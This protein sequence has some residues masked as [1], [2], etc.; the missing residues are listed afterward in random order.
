MSFYFRPFHENSS[1]WYL[2]FPL[3]RFRK[4]AR[5]EQVEIRFNFCSSSYV[6]L[7]KMFQIFRVS[8]QSIKSLDIFIIRNSSF[9]LLYIPWLI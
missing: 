5:K 3:I 8:F 2:N 7:Y 9:S 4:A 1:I 6:T